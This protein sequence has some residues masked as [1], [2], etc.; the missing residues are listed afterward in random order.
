MGLARCLCLIR[1]A[2]GAIVLLSL[3]SLPSM[4]V[5]A[6][7]IA[8]SE[9]ASPSAIA[10][11]NPS[12][13]S[14][15]IVRFRPEV[16]PPLGQ[17]VGDPLLAE[18]QGAVG[19]PLG[20]APPTRAGDQILTLTDP[21]SL[22]EAKRLINI[23]RMRRDVLRAEMDRSERVRFATRQSATATPDELPIVRRFIVTLTDPAAGDLARNNQRL[24]PEWDQLLSDGARVPMHVVRPTVGGAWIVEML[25][26]VTRSRAADLAA[27]LEA[28]PGVRYATPDYPVKKD[29]YFPNDPYFQN[30]RQ[31][32][33]ANPLTTSYY[34]IDAPEAWDIT[35]GSDLV[36][37]V[38]D[39]GVRP[40]GEF[41]S[42]LL[43]GYDFISDPDNSHDGLGRH[44]SGI[45]PGNWRSADDCPGKA[46]QDSDWH[47]THVSGIIAATGDNSEGIAGINWYAMILPVRVLG[48]CGGDTSDILEAMVWS[49][50]LPVPGVPDNTTPARVINM[51]LGGKGPCDDQY[52]SQVDAVLARGT[53]IAVSAG[54]D[55]ADIE[56]QHPANCYGVSTVAA[57]DPYGELAS[58]SNY[59]VS[60]D[61][62]APGGDQNRY[63][64]EFGIW[65]T[66][67]TGTM[68]PEF[69]TY[70][71]YQGTSQAAPHVSGVASLMLS[72]NPTLTPAQIKTIMADTSSYFA[73]D[74]VCRTSGDCGAGIVNAYYAVKQALQ[75]NNYQGLWF[76]PAES[77]WGINFAHQGDTI[78]ASWFTFD[79]TG[80]AWW[81]V[82]TAAKVGPG[83]YSGTLF[84]GTGPSFDA[85][86]FPP[87]GSPGGAI[88]SAVGTGTITFGDLNNATFDYTV[89]GVS[90]SKA[91]TRQLFGPQPIC[92]FG[93]QANLALA[94]NYTDLWWAA[95]AG[96]EAGW[97]INLTHQGDIIF[98]T[99]FTF[100]RDR[101]PMWLVV[102]ATKTAP[103]VY[104]GSQVYR[105]TGPPFNA[106]P[107]PPIGAAGGP[108]GSVVGT[109]TFSFANGNAATFSYTV[110]GV[111][112]SKT[113]TREVFT[114]PGT[115]CQ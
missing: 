33:M 92:T 40:H 23:L 31:R 19:R 78:F 85:V 102:Q 81:L 99:W 15:L 82:M 94:T 75:L 58:Y 51:S 44:A 110:N 12:L 72:V 105:L 86:P 30:G 52:Q 114:A 11:S 59:S 55:S 38:V 84:Q 107:F 2:L 27:M 6:E 65:S 108:T 7:P 70:V 101:T 111:T 53:F 96:S 10:T 24:G 97:G 21:V 41:S 62:A 18:L 57:T 87:L 115:T 4:G 43:D 95:P 5:V 104:S 28:T 88:G 91:I 98:A 69:S 89:N 80:K 56:G 9:A 73:S 48:T 8:G 26:A 100:D 22:T 47:G 3:V 1:R 83:T 14:R 71:A 113:I 16:H 67:N 109:A 46:A 50:G 32:D 106:V 60:V 35:V 20:V 36:V 29:A 25:T 45:D 34:G 39:T 103:G 76:N 93:G 112:Q 61:I 68:E 63:G 54:N 79:A 17:V 37:A 77:G 90:Q 13:V 66:L 49:A 74:S 64:N 42:R